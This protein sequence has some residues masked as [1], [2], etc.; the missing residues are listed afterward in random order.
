MLLGRG[1]GGALF[2]RKVSAAVVTFPALSNAAVVGTPS[3]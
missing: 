2:L 3:P 1:N